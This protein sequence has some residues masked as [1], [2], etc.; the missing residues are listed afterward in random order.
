MANERDGMTNERNRDDAMTGG[1]DDRQG[2]R[3]DESERMGDESSAERMRGT[4]DDL[5]ED[6]FEDTDESDEEE[7]E[8]EDGTI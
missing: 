3:R 2:G 8:E 7:E 1:T 4:G 5:D 6:E